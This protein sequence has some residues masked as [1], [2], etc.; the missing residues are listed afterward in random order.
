MPSVL[1]N[2]TPDAYID[3]PQKLSRNLAYWKERS[4]M[5]G[6]MPLDQAVRTIGDPD[7]QFEARQDYPGRW[8]VSVPRYIVACVR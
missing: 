6:C 5:P 3:T 8:V 4:F 7:K 1:A 2:T